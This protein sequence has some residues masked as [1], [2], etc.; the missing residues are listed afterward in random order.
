[1]SAFYSIKQWENYAKTYD[2]PRSYDA[3]YIQHRG[4]SAMA[5]WA[6]HMMVAQLTHRR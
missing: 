6:V 5:I 2:F 3:Q 1:M 4:L